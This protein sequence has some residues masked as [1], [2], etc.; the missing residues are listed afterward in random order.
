MSSAAALSQ[1][2]NQPANQPASPPAAQPAS[3]PELARTP[4]QIIKPV[5]ANEHRASDHPE[6][7]EYLARERSDRTGGH[8]WTERIV[9]NET[10][11]VR[12]LL[13]VDGKPLSPEEVQRERDRLTGIAAHPEPFLAAEK[14]ER[15]SEHS[16]R[17]MLDLLATDFLFDNVR[18]QDG[19]W[20]LDYRPDPAVAT[21][22]MEDEVL[23]GM[24]G[25]VQ[26]DARQMR[27]MHIDGH[28]A[29]PV[30]IGFGLLASVKAGSRFASDR[31]EIGGHWRTVHVLTAIGGKAALFKS[32]AK[33]NDITRTEF[34]YFDHQLTV[35][36]A[37]AVLLQPPAQT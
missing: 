21:G 36:E 32:V 10:A 27:L 24:S 17:H 3:Q 37:V 20:S 25:T 15:G 1:S 5:V 4:L 23:H 28:L 35:P 2:A 31:R 34:R 30:N 19:V 14:D 22:G 7:Y 18:L 26:V 11:R 6:C 13:A 29:Q 33:N 12:L 16:A 8:E 9:E